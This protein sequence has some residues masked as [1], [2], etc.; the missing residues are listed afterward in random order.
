CTEECI[1]GTQLLRGTK[2]HF[3][4]RLCEYRP[5]GAGLGR[6]T[7]GARPPELWRGDPHPRPPPRLNCGGRTCIGK[8]QPPG[9]GL[10]P[11]TLPL[12]A[13]CSTIEL[14]GRTTLSI[15]YQDNSFYRTRAPHDRR[16][17]A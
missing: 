15:Q 4:Q 5:P 8:C 16:S 7:T 1:R 12:T 9:A 11:A 10:E 17:P 13:G 14:P 2:R 3:I 6:H